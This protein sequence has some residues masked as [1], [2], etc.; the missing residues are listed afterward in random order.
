MGD[1]V[2]VE[3]RT[4]PGINKPGGVGRVIRLDN[5]PTGSAATVDVRYVLGGDERGIE[6][7]YV[8]RHEDLSRGGRARPRREVMN[9]GRRD[10]GFRTRTKPKPKTDPLPETE[11]DPEPQSEADPKP[12]PQ[13]QPQAKAKAAG[14]KRK[15]KKN[16]KK[17]KAGGPR[18]ASA[19]E[20][21]GSAP[22]A[23]EPAP[24]SIL[25]Q[26]ASG[27]GGGSGPSRRPPRSISFGS[28]AVREHRRTMSGADGVPADGG[29]PLG[30]SDEVVADLGSYPVEEFERRR[31]A[32]LRARYVEVMERRRASYER[33]RREAAEGGGGASGNGGRMRAGSVASHD[34]APFEPIRAPGGVLETRQYDY[35]SRKRPSLSTPAADLDLGDL[36][37]VLEDGKNPLFG[38]SNEDERK[39]LLIRDGEP[40]NGSGGGGRSGSGGSP[41]KHGL[42]QDLQQQQQQ[43]QRPRSKSNADQWSRKC[44]PSPTSG[45]RASRSRRK[46]SQSDADLGVYTS[47]DVIHIR[48]ELERIRAGRSG[49]T[50]IGCGCRKLRVLLPGQAGQKKRKQHRMTERR[51][52]EELRKRG[53]LNGVSA[54]LN[55]EGLEQLLHDAV[56]RGPCCWGNDCPCARNGIGCQADTCSC[57]HPG[58]D[59]VDGK[60]KKATESLSDHQAE[61]GVRGIEELCGNPC[62]MYVVDFAK[63]DSIRRRFISANN[64]A[65]EDGGTMTCVPMDAGADADP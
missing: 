25:K 38:A 12:Q 63:I 45:D 46:R 29:W 55:R 54:K 49:N 22:P 39:F 6:L 37:A 16:S 65:E 15:K 51:V 31:Q 44:P 34:G 53:L 56:E 61:L 42:S 20:P 27:G 8:R 33:R 13:P 10:G 19:A 35:K 4:W 24:R 21:G 47:T 18:A 30:L 59:D 36:L 7:Q 2:D 9:L 26:P 5:G 60:Q 52:Q 3:A 58:H 48:N 14:G 1:L 17:K 64:S 23:A 62:G 57:W 11:T 50:A 40:A 41:N 28:V 32:E 43:Q